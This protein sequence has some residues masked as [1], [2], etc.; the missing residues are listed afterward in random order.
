VPFFL[1]N[2]HKVYYNDQ[3]TGR[4]V[5]FLH[6]NTA[7]SKLFSFMQRQFEPYC[8]TILIDFPGHGQS[9][10]LESFEPDFWYENASC[11][12]H[13]CAELGLSSIS[14]IGTSGGSITA[15]DI[16]MEA[17]GLVH[18]II[19]DSFVPELNQ[20][21]VDKL[22]GQRNRDMED[23]GSAL[24][25]QTMHGPDWRQIVEADNQMLR[26][27]LTL[28]NQYFHKDLS[29]VACPVLLTGSNADEYIDN[30]EAVY[31]HV[32]S[33]LQDCSVVI[34]PKG[35]HPA[36]LSNSQDFIPIAKDFLDLR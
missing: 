24:F 30:V 27:H 23:A 9:E 17:P 5:I 7:S 29:S 8:R 10:R 15:F 33:Q 2:Q 1:H 31:A 22:I 35:L 20:Y 34:F 21:R 14:L 19:A 28:P 32:A 36:M 12:I 13:L 6:G 4:P 26:R 16:A 18:K 25:W 3:A 11:V